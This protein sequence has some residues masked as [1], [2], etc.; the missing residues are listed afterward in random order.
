MSITL[1]PNYT[2]SS[3]YKWLTKFRG[4]K[5]VLQN[6]RS[7]AIRLFEYSILEDNIYNYRIQLISVKACEM[8]WAAKYPDCVETPNVRV[9]DLSIRGR[10]GIRSN[11]IG[12]ITRLTQYKFDIPVSYFK[13]NEIMWFYKKDMDKAFK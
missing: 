11:N 2:L 5:K 1:R 9:Y 13:P 6:L 7:R 4:N 10:L 12:A 8:Y 3:D